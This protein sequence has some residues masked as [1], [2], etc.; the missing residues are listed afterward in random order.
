MK[1]STPGSAPD[2]VS[3][4]SRNS[5]NTLRWLWKVSG[6]NKGYIAA[7]TLVQAVQGG[8][9]VLYALLLRNIV[10]S[11]VGKK[12][13]EFRRHVLFIIL[14]VLIQLAVAAVIRWLVELAKSDIENTFK[15]RLVDNILRRDYAAVSATHT[16]EWLNHITNDT[17]VVA[18]GA[19]DILPG[20]VGTV[21][22]L[23]SALIMIIALDPWFGYILVPGGIL[24]VFLTYLFRGA[25]KRLHKNI[26]ESDGRLRVYLQERL[27]SLMV[28]KSFVGEEQV[29]REAGLRME[30]HKA[31][32]LR[33]NRFSNVANIGF[34]A[35][36]QGMYLIGVIYCA[37]GIMTGSVTYGTL[38][39]IMQLIGQVQGPFVNISGYLPR[40]YALT[41]SAERLM[42]VESFAED[43][44]KMPAA[45]A[46]GYYRDCFASLGLSHVF[47]SYKTSYKTNEKTDEKTDEKTKGNTEE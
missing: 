4:N 44:D 37:H 39:A 7:L 36:M 43:G 3:R 40:W 11:A 29:S 15:Q 22:R 12:A 20:L 14:L 45:G 9:G 27:S 16:A 28:I 21:V 34:G 19:V 6:K 25:L 8:L 42:E 24:L 35:S 18:G 47:F 10:D 26:Q 13:I 32:R 23:V 33:R 1:N 30:D 46:Q 5:Q 38:T 31:A 2:R 17:T 41:A